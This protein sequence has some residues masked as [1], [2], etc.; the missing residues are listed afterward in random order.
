MSGSIICGVDDSK[1][2]KSAARVAR[3]LSAELGLPLIFVHCVEPTA[4]NG[5]QRAT[6][7]R[8]QRLTAFG[9]HPDYGAE[10]LVDVGPLA[11]RL[12]AVAGKRHA[13][14]I[15]LGATHL[16]SSPAENVSAEV[17]EQAQC[18]LVIVPPGGT[19]A[20]TNGHH[21]HAGTEFEDGIA[22]FRFGS[23][24]EDGRTDYAGGIAR[25]SLGSRGCEA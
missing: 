22:R 8:L 2:A 21:G 5:S 19:A 7:E 6:V 1:S 12:V 20:A 13:A 16:C 11:E 3:G 23:L 4:E 24:S 9:N 14:F 25:F 18:P 15:V 17:L 10:W